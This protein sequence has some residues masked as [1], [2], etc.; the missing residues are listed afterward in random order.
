MYISN[1]IHLHIEPNRARDRQTSTGFMD[2]ICDAR[3]LLCT[4]SQIAS[5]TLHH[6]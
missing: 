1:H 6:A 4:G 3:L 5:G 2:L